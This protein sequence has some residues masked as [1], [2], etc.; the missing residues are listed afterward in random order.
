MLDGWRKETEN[1]LPRDLGGGDE[2]N[3]RHI[4]RYRIHLPVREHRDR[5]LVI[6]LVRVMVDH[7]VQLRTRRHRVQQQD[8]GNQQ[9]TDKCLAAR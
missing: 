8:D 3:R 1:R 7:L 4:H 6:R 2:E 5:A 9:G